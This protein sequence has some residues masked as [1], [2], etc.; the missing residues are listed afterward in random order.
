[1][2]RHHMEF[3]KGER[4]LIEGN[5]FENN[6]GGTEQGKAVLLFGQNGTEHKVVN[7]FTIRNNIFLNT[8]TGIGVIAG[9]NTGRPSG[10]RIQIHN[11]LWQNIWGN[12][13]SRGIN[14]NY[15]DG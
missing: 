4:W 6:W 11:N 9:L 13:Y 2:N 14:S 5:I 8:P 3:K 15:P 1:M 10:Q 7:D 12:L